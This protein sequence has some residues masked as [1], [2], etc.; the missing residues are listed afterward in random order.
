[1]IINNIQGILLKKPISPLE[2]ID[3]FEPIF[4]RT[5]VVNIAYYLTLSCWFIFFFWFFELGFFI[6]DKFKNV[7]VDA[8]AFKSGWRAIIKNMT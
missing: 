4:E 2:D 3:T 7:A 6:S 1:M 8:V 5:L